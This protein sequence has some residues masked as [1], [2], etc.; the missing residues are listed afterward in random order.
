MNGPAD[1]GGA[2]D[3]EWAA[4]P[5]GAPVA[6]D[7]GG[8]VWDQSSVPAPSFRWVDGSVR[9]APSHP[10]VPRTVVMKIRTA[11]EWPTLGY[12]KV[13]PRSVLGAF[14]VGLMVREWAR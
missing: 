12:P 10:S 1:M 13:I 2:A 11:N 6:A 8:S 3:A 14:L 7:P 9:E 4:S 5:D